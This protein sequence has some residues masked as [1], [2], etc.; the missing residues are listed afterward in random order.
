MRLSS[1]PHVPFGQ[2]IPIS[3][4]VKYGYDRAVERAAHDRGGWP[5]VEP[6]NRAEHELADWEILM[7]SIENVL[8]R[9]GVM[10]VDEMRRGI[11]SMPS[12]QY[13]AATYYERWLYTT[14][15]IL[16][17]KGILAAGELDARVE[18]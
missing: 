18:G 12:A 2:C 1:S 6:I 13:E 3:E 8:E 16:V 4:Y 10:N 17:E 9:R 14:E 5:T 11:E 15:T 7:D